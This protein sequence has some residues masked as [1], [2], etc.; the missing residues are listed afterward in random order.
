MWYTLDCLEAARTGFIHADHL[1]STSLT[2]DITGTVVAET[3]YLPYGEERW[4]TN[5]FCIDPNPLPEYN[6]HRESC[7]TQVEVSNELKF[8]HL[9]RS[10]GH[11]RKIIHLRSTPLDYRTFTACPTEDG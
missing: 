4:I 7:A 2:T 11:I 10:A 3:R 5:S 1:G 8:R 9:A 6:I